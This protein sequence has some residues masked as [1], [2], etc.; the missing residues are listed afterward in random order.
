MN[1]RALAT[2]A[3]ISLILTGCAPAEDSTPSGTELERAFAEGSS[4][5]YGTRGSSCSSEGSTAV[6]KSAG[7]PGSRAKAPGSLTCRKAHGALVWQ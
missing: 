5:T 4:N 2:A 3:L 6:E 1:P 7:S